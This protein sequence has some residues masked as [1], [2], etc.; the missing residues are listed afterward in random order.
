VIAQQYGWTSSFLVAAVLSIAGGFAWLLVEPDRPLSAA[1]VS[2][3]FGVLLEDG[4][5][6]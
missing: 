1:S 6:A 3:E 5:K 4:K 2:K